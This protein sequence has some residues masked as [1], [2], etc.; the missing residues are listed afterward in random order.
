MEKNPVPK[1]G[2]GR[3]NAAENRRARRER[4]YGRRRERRAGRGGV[5]GLA[6]GGGGF[7]D[8]EGCDDH[9]EFAEGLVEGTE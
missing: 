7:C 8:G 4:I 1:R 3:V 9:L 6:R 2:G 5:G